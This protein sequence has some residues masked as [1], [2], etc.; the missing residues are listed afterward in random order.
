LSLLQDEIKKHIKILVHPL[1]PEETL[2]PALKAKLTKKEFKL[3][4][5]WAAQEDIDVLK[6]KLNL[7]TQRYDEMA[8]KLIK[9][10][11]QEK[12]KQAICQP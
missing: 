8:A 12:V 7:D 1:K 3:L 5:A 11:N 4:N 9:K 2:I 6:A 10:L